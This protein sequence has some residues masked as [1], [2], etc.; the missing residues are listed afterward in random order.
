[1]ISKEEQ[2]AIILDFIPKILVEEEFDRL[3]NRITTECPTDLV[4][5]KKLCAI[6]YLT[7]AADCIVQQDEDLKNEDLKNYENNDDDDENNAYSTSS[8]FSM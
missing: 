2:L 4:T 5:L 3:F 8:S 7:G 1:M 6:F